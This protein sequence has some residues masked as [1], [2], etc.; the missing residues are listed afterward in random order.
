MQTLTPESGSR[1]GP[2]QAV[3][4]KGQH[5]PGLLKQN[6]ACLRQVQTLAATFEQGGS[7]HLLQPADLLAEGRL[8]DEG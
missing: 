2:H 1:P 5:R 6:A 3:F 7:D 4:D 8:G